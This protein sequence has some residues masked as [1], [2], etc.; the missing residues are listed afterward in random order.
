MEIEELEFD[1]G[2]AKFDL[3]LEV[4]ERDEGSIARLSTALICLS[5]RR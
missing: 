4:V 5:H 3:T 1:S 2:L